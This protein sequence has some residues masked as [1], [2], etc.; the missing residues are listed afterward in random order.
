[1]SSEK[2]KE[3]TP[4][5]YR[6]SP[7]RTRARGEIWSS[8]IRS[9]ARASE[10]LWISTPNPRADSSWQCVMCGSRTLSFVLLA[11]LLASYQTKT[12]NLM[13]CNSPRR[14]F[15][16]TSAWRENFLTHELA[17]PYKHHHHHPNTHTRL[18]KI[19]QAA[20]DA[21]GP[22]RVRV[23]VCVCVCL[24]CVWG[25]HTEAGNLFR[26]HRLLVGLFV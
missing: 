5:N 4:K 16:F 25:L 22:R 10:S 24:W 6:T 8:L 15:L 26:A 11:R 7:F 18:K 9:R 20:E 19:L 13:R 2:E 23:C 21:A 12:K 17:A 3:N 1:M 14:H